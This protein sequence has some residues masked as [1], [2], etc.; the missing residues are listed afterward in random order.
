MNPKTSSGTGRQ[1]Q[2]TTPGC[3]SCIHFHITHDKG[4]PYGCK[5]MGFKSR[6]IP[7]REVLLSSGIEC[8]MFA[9]K[10]RNSL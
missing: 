10:K 6:L 8:Q 1:G 7:S 2:G 4:F 3:F 5:A 9:P